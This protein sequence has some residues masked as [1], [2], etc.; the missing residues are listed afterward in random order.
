MSKL[1]RFSFL[2]GCMLL[3]SACEL[4]FAESGDTCTEG[5][6]QFYDDFEAGHDCGWVEYSQGGAVIAVENGALRIATSQL[7]QI[8][9]TNPGRNFD[10]AV[11]TVLARQVGGPNDN[12]YGV[13]CRYQGPENF[14]VFL[15]SG[16]GHYAIGKYQSGS[17]QIAYLSGEG[18][19]QFTEAINQG[20]ATNHLQVGCVGNELSLSVNGFQL[21]TVTDNAFA[22]GDIGL[23]LSTFEMGTA[24][25]QF[26]NIRVTA[27]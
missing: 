18:Q 14:Y 1:A 5:G 19:Y 11:I 6:S 12:A 24:V 21:A 22:E 13:I 27:P 4:P 23:A 16:D 25:I 10:D 7:G 2:L 9:W 20:Q 17:N 26:D 8:W 3:L 15:I